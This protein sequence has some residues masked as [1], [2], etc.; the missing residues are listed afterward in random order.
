MDDN[1]TSDGALC[2]HVKPS[3]KSG[4]D[5]DSVYIQNSD[6]SRLFV[7]FRSLGGK[8][9]STAV[10]NSVAMGYCQYLRNNLIHIMGNKLALFKPVNTN[11]K[12]ITLLIVPEPLR[13]KLFSH[14]HTG[15]TGAHMGEYNTF[16]RLRLR[17]YWST[18]R[19]EVTLWCKGY[20]HFFAYNVWQTRLSEL[21]FSWSI[22]VP[23]WIMHVDLWSPGHQYDGNGNK[24]CL[25][26]AMCDVT[27]F[28][29]IHSY[30]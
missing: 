4:L 23:F 28:C 13:H 7:A 29:G 9:F 30:C 1:D 20:A 27:Q 11:S 25:M 2:Y 19:D 12:Y 24:D 10:I 17:F 18:M 26:N 5:W 6:T 3:P 16:F 21:H 14:Y 15:P 22:T 8:H